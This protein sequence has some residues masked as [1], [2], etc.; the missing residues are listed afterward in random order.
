MLP[1]ELDDWED[2]ITPTDI[3]LAT[4]V[5]RRKSIRH[6]MLPPHQFGSHICYNSPKIAVKR[7]SIGGFMQNTP[8]SPVMSSMRSHSFSFDGKVP[9][10]EE[11]VPTSPPNQST[12]Q[13]AVETLR[14]PIFSPKIEALTELGPSAPSHLPKSPARAP[15][16]TTSPKSNGCPLY[17]NT[18]D[19]MVNKYEQELN[20]WPKFLESLEEKANGLLQPSLPRD[21]IM[22]DPI[23]EPFV[24]FILPDHSSSP[25]VE[26]L[27][28]RTKR[29]YSKI[30]I[31]LVRTK[32]LQEKIRC[33]MSLLRESK[34]KRLLPRLAQNSIPM[35]VKD[36]FAFIPC[37]QE[38]DALP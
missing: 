23:L 33:Q 38:T 26:E 17:C 27:Q 32:M 34:L 29:A 10:R 6:S 15:E 18:V 20:E 19:D 16:P 31:G 30:M 37:L 1:N 7:K 5:T 36:L 24:E 13:P 3:A 12:P 22:K 11:S 21:Q 35:S 9:R 14:V 25:S 2:E 4:T 8:E 28:R